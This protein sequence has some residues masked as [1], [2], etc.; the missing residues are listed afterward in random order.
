M[1]KFKDDEKN[2]H[3]IK[4]IKKKRELELLRSNISKQLQLALLI[5]NTEREIMYLKEDIINNACS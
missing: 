3:I 2:P 4:L 5:E 1:N